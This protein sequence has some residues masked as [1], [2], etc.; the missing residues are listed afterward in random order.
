MLKRIIFLFAILL[1]SC[2]SVSVEA[3][4]TAV[5]SG[6]VTSTLPPTKPGFV[7][8]TLTPIPLETTAPTSAVTIPANCKDSAVLLRDVTIE[9]ETKLKAGEKFTKTWEFQNN[10]TCP[11]VGYAVKFAAGD[12][13]GAPLSA[14]IATTLSGE[15][16]Q[17]SVELVAPSADGTYT[18][19][20]TLNNTD[21]K[22]VPIGIEKT[23][24]VKII[25]GN[26]VLPTKS[27]ASVP[28]VP[29]NKNS[30]CA[31]SPNDGYVQQLIAMI[32]AARSKAK[33]KELAVNA[34]LMS[35]AQNHSADM[36]CNN[37]NGHTG[38]DG[39][40]I[41]DR[42]IRAGYSPSHYVEIVAIGNPQDAMNQWAADQAHWDAVLDFSATEFGVGYA[43][44]ANSDFGGYITVDFASR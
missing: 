35:A 25:V 7:P 20:F 3:P 13:M 10:G 14:P 44:Y 19:Y 17:I 8:M 34:Q 31:Y 27:G 5:E 21:G 4:P 11:W 23:F 38:S 36:A 16:I 15:K 28:Y 39:S 33:L 2:I 22:D 42:L 40:W 43:Y 1:T 6:F 9:D 29:N 24:W 30:K 12:Q 26:G 32:N 18:G 41:G 37:F